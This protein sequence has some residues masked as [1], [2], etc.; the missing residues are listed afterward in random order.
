MT[1]LVRL[2]SDRERSA[3][4]ARYIYNRQ[5]KSA[6]GIRRRGGR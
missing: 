2:R 5:M 3:P 1:L 4:E 6:S